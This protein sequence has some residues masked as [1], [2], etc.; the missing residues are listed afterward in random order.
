MDRLRSLAYFIACAQQGSFSAAARQLEVTVPAVAKLVTALER[1]LGVSLFERSAHGLALTATGESYLEA[2]APA[3]RALEEVDEQVRSTSSRIRG[4]VVIGVQNLVAR[5]LIAPALPRFHA[6]HPEIQVDLR[7]ATQVSS[8]DA[9][10]VD[11]YLS[12]AW[13]KRDDMVH[14]ALGIAAFVVCAAPAYWARAGKPRH[15]R[16]LESHEC[17]LIRTQLG[18]AMDVWAFERDGERQ[19]VTVRGWLLCSNMHRDVAIEMAC[20]GQGV[21]RLLR[22]TERAR[23]ESGELEPALE[24]WTAADGPPLVLSYRPSARRIARVRAVMQFLEEALRGSLSTPLPTSAI[25]HAPR[26][27]GT[28]VSR[29]SSVPVTRRLRAR[30]A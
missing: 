29:A 30:P 4:T 11:L 19:E 20:A 15:P 9:P 25:P 2:A 8:P 1:D 26:W 21:V 14:R 13:P 28:H 18:T 7:D 3:V 5:S 24:A 6:R 23:F 10:G 27:A 12:L 17:L 16:E 22:D